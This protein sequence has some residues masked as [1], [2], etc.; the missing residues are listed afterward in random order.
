MSIELNE[1]TKW[2]LGRP[3]FYCAQVAALL[4]KNGADIPQSSKEEQAHVIYW[5]LTMYEKHGDN[6]KEIAQ[7]ELNKISREAAA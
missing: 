3:N 5:F 6:W 2:I 4:R 1:Q 7:E